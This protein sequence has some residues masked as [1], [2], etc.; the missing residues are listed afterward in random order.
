MYDSLDPDDFDDEDFPQ[1]SPEQISHATEMVEA[2]EA[3]ATKLGLYQIGAKLA[4][5]PQED[6]PLRM[7]IIADFVPG[8]V[9]WSDR[10]QA[11]DDHATDEAFRDIERGI[12]EAEFEEYRRGL[13]GG[14]ED[15]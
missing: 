9:A 5:N 12:E 6:G 1:P 8:E 3:V 15:G 10:V 7:L 14:T 13:M 11:P 2:L 4:V